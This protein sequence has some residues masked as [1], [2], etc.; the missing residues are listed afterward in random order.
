MGMFT[1][2]FSRETRKKSSVEL[3]SQYLAKDEESEG[4]NIV[5]NFAFCLS[6]IG[7]TV[8]RL[9]SGDSLMLLIDSIDSGVSI[10]RVREIKRLFLDTMLSEENIPSGARVYIIVSANTFE[11]AR[12]CDCLDVSTGKHLRFED[13]ESY[14]SYIVNQSERQRKRN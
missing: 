13:Y 3:V 14:A 12:D 10:D 1:A 9:R 7:E 4:E 5:S 6:G 11:L 2:E 8:S